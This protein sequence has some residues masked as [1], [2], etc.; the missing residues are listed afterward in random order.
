M[1]KELLVFF[2]FYAKAERQKRWKTPNK[3]VEADLDSERMWLTRL[4]LM[5]SCHRNR[6]NHFASMQIPPP[7][8]AHDFM[9]YLYWFVSLSVSFINWD[10]YVG[11][12]IWISV[13]VVFCVYTHQ[14]WTQ[15]Y[16]SGCG[17]RAYIPVP[18]CGFFCVRLVCVLVWD[19]SVLFQPSKSHRSSVERNAIYIFYYPLSFSP[20]SYIPIVSHP[21][22][23]LIFQL[24]SSLTP[25]ILA[26]F[27]SPISLSS[28]VSFPSI[29]F[30]SSLPHPVHFSIFLFSQFLL[31]SHIL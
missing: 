5:F 29:P 22:S 3:S 19:P 28:F 27:S 4:S 21:L 6:W 12:P 8:P 23:D 31:L 2:F 9:R 13:I 16:G 14:C 25:P 15:I 11:N 18:V 26:L 1:I 24:F 17:W 30:F 10:N 20:L 7:P